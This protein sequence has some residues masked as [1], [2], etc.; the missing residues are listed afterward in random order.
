MVRDA[1]IAGRL[2]RDPVLRE[3]AGGELVLS[4]VVLVRNDGEELRFPVSVFGSDCSA[5]MAK[6][7]TG[8][9]VWVEGEQTTG[10][11]GSMGIRC[12][13]LDVTLMKSVLHSV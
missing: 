6:L 4:L 10:A 7:G 9:T 5:L 3:T 12:L 2:A 11:D 13:P 8:D 1:M